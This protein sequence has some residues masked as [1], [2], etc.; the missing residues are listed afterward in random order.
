MTYSPNFFRSGFFL[1]FALQFSFSLQ[2]Q[3]HKFPTLGGVWKNQMEYHDGPKVYFTLDQLTYQQ[4]TLID[5]LVYKF[6]KG[7]GFNALHGNLAILEDTLQRKIFLRFL[8]GAA[9][10]LSDTNYLIYNFSMGIGDSMEVDGIGL[11]N[12]IYWKVIDT[13]KV[14]IDGTWRNYLDVYSIGIPALKHDRWIEGIGS[15]WILTRPVLTLLGWEVLSKL[16]CFRDTSEGVLYE[17]LK[18]SLPNINCSDNIGV[19]KYDLP[20]LLVYPNPVTNILNFEIPGNEGPVVIV[21]YDF[22]GKKLGEYN[23][24][25]ESFFLNLDHLDPGP[26][27]LKITNNFFYSEQLIFKL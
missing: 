22:Y 14:L 10:C 8:N 21:I 6:I 9:C 18:N 4:D 5:G 15:Q 7:S 3:Y 1:V 24:P 12:P 2:A 17:P 27:L 23:K 19:V 13:G 26:Y 25:G 11:Q 16:V 20:E